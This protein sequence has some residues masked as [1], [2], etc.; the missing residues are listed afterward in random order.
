M[1]N[2]R[3]FLLCASTLFVAAQQ[4]APNSGEVSTRDAPPT[5]STRVD[6]VMVPVVVRDKQGRAVGTLQKEDFILADKGKPQIITRYALEKTGDRLSIK[7]IVTEG[8]TEDPTATP[9]AV[10]NRFTAYIF[11]DLHIDFGDMVRARD[12]AG[13]RMDAMDATERAAI[14]TT[15]GRVTLDFTDDRESIHRTLAK[16]MP[17]ANLTATQCPPLTYYMA[18]Q[19]QIG[20]PTALSAA[21]DD[22]MACAR[23]DPSM[24]DVATQM[25]QQAA[26]AAVALGRQDTQ[27]ALSVIKD[28]TRSMAAVP[29]IRSIVLVSP[30]FLVNIDNRE[31]ESDILDRA[32]RNK[33]T[34]HSL[35]ARGLYVPGSDLSRSDRS[36]SVASQI[37]KSAYERQ[38]A[39]AD[40][41]IMAELALGTAGNFYQNNNDFDE[42]FRRLA[43]L[44]EF[45]YILG[46]APQNLKYDGAFHSLKVSLKGKTPYTVE[47]RRGYYAPKREPNP[48]EQS[49]RE[50]TEALFSR[51]ET[52]DIPV[53]MQTQ[54]FKPSLDEA[55]LSIV[56]KIDLKRL[57]FRKEEGRNRNTLTILSGVFDR[58]GKLVNAIEKTIE[59]RL[60]EETLDARLAAGL[61]VKTSFDLTPG[62]YIIRV[63]V[64]DS[65][66]Q[67]MTARN[68]AVQIP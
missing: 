54:F 29:G 46:F 66:G 61:G 52:V 3:V 23:L 51:D 2:R 16:L 65:E 8:A 18:E 59:M 9:I 60:K 36:G 35:D 30:G 14:F 24:R 44:P 53:E 39:T 26:S 56:A 32:I 62:T 42:G 38:S 50:M 45:V 48:A 37:A 47:A 57:Q 22:T 11:D 67:L 25:A 12:A 58:N 15:T 40:A 6:L 21:V 7:P 13:H 49:R 33:V 1:R 17:R 28:V 68:G 41:D 55:K 43:A 34:I 4:P 20:D 31:Y 10:A 19:I 27:V 63:V 5:F 64:R